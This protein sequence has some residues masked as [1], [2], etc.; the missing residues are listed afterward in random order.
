MSSAKVQAQNNEQ[1]KRHYA[2]IVKSSCVYA[3]FHTQKRE[4]SHTMVRL[5]QH[6]YSLGLVCL[7]S[8]SPIESGHVSYNY[9][10]NKRPTLHGRRIKKHISALTGPDRT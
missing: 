4:Q 2:I 1:Q 5:L 9:F 3:P 8:A 7:E 10:D 6:R